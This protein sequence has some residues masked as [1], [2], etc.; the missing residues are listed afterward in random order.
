MSR[1]RN[2]L[3]CSR[4]G[5]RASGAR[6]D[7]LVVTSL[8]GRLHLALVHRGDRL[9]SALASERRFC[10]SSLRM[11]SDL[12]RLRANSGSLGAPK[13]TKHNNKQQDPV[14]RLHGDL[15]SKTLRSV[16]SPCAAATRIA[17]GAP[18][19]RATAPAPRVM[20]A[21]AMLSNRP[22]S[23]ASLVTPAVAVTSSPSSSIVHARNVLERPPARA[24]QADRWRRTRGSRVKP[25]AA[26]RR[27]HR[28]LVR[29]RCRDDPIDAQRAVVVR[30]G[31]TSTR[32]TGRRRW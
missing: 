9:G 7:A 25:S 30:R 15:R 29:H 27:G 16:Y 12:P 28:A 26:R 14:D 31:G 3:R 23:H 24:A 21:G 22:A 13:S 4:R 2:S 17:P 10:V 8:L 1:L 18:P 6:P 20:S 5:I 32:D 19:L 11:F